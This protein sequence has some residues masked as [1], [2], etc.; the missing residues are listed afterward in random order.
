ML[1]L[2]LETDNCNMHD[3]VLVWAALNI[4]VDGMNV[5]VKRLQKW[6]VGIQANKM[7][8]F[9]CVARSDALMEWKIVLKD[10]IED[11]IEYISTLLD[12]EQCGKLYSS[13]L[14][15]KNC[16]VTCIKLNICKGKS[17]NVHQK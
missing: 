11:D 12:V 5:T 3:L 7:I 9:V 1:F 10:D 16:W 8:Y 2:I 15:S 17:L 6:F 4:L 13:W 14:V